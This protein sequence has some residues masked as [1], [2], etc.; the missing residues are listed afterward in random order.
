MEAW[1]IAEALHSVRHLLVVLEQMTEEELVRAI[2]LEEETLRRKSILERLR[3]RARV[4][5]LKTHD[6]T[7]QHKIDNQ[8]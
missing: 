4:L 8:F 3:R 5:A 2:A 7:L 1:R 6:A